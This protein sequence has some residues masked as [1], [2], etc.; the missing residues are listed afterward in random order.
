VNN[1]TLKI[2]ERLIQAEGDLTIFDCGLNRQID[3][4]KNVFLCIDKLGK[5]DYMI[6]VVD[7][8]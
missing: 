5:F 6:N 2:E 3:I 4:Q 7:M 8:T 1:L